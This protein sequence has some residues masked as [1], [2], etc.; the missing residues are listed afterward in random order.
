MG[1]AGK[2]V[3]LPKADKMRKMQM[4]KNLVKLSYLFGELALE[5][6]HRKR[7]RGK[8]SEVLL[9]FLLKNACSRNH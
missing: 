3:Q 1:N 9:N 2:I 5:S 8:S 6:K 4:S 7:K